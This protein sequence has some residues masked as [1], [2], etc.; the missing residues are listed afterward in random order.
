MEISLLTKW[1]DTE[2]FVTNALRCV[3]IQWHGWPP[4]ILFS[5]FRWKNLEIS[6]KTGYFWGKTISEWGVIVSCLCWMSNILWV[7]MIQWLFTISNLHMTCTCNSESLI[8]RTYIRS[9]QLISEFT[10]DWLVWPWPLRGCLEI[11]LWCSAQ[12]QDIY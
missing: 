5:P 2:S 3:F 12:T 9:Q 1:G 4:R 10:E 7:S 6:G 8:V 11:S